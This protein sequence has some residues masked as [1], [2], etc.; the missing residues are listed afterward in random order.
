M[1]SSLEMTYDVIGKL[2]RAAT[3]QDIC[4]GLTSFTGRYGLTSMMAASL[5]AP[6]E[7]AS[8]MR[9]RHL[10]VGAFPAGW[11]DHYFKQGYAHID[12]VVSRG[13]RDLSPFLWSESAPFARPEHSALVS[14]MFGEACEFNLK[15][16]FVV[17]M[18]TIDG[19]IIAASLGGEAAEVPQTA[20]G[21]ISTISAF[22]LG[23][24]IE[25]RDQERKRN[26]SGVTP[27]EV[28]CLKWAAEGKTE[29]EISEILSISEH[30]ADKH[31]SNARRKLG[32]AN[33]AQAVANAIR[34]GLIS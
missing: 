28:E 2:S 3:A 13:R 29:W 6:N 8:L 31:L 30:T 4:D 18:V 12:P 16:G 5:P 10:L 9:R 26:L 22:A 17:P 11:M 33:C 7:R 21:M 34:W 32:A 24:A 27:R 20:R 25:L 19:A 1:P 14:R 23:R 15:A